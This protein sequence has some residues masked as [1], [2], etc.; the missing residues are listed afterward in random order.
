MDGA[1][2]SVGAMNTAS[3]RQTESKYL[4]P[5]LTTPSSQHHNFL[6]LNLKA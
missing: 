6:V 1:V 3:R 5:I 4:S 2:A